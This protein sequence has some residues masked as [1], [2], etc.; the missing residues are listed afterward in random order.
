[1]SR[2]LAVSTLA[3]LVLAVGCAGTDSSDARSAPEVADTPGSGVEQAG[4]DI[5]SEIDSDAPVASSREEMYAEP[6]QAVPGGVVA[7]HFPGGIGRGEAFILHQHDGVRWE[8][9]YT[10]LSVEGKPAPTQWWPLGH[11]G[12]GWD[13]V[14]IDGPGP[15]FVLVPYTA[16]PGEYLVCATDDNALCA[17]LDVVEV[18]PVTAE[19]IDHAE[20]LREMRERYDQGDDLYF[21]ELLVLV[22][23][24][25]PE[26]AGYYLVSGRLTIALAG[27][28]DAD[29]AADA[30]AALAELTEDDALFGRSVDHVAV[31]YSWLELFGWMRLILNDAHVELP[32]HFYDIDEVENRIALGVEGSASHGDVVRDHFEQ[33]GV[34]ADVLL[35]V[36]SGPPID[37]VDE[38]GPD[39]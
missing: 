24:S 7:L 36:E 29:R 15:Q 27:E 8:P 18:A 12:A 39:D 33:F 31:D 28:A 16:P 6:D 37:D 30:A 23:E 34:P 38:G 10:L 5:D 19:A 22:A 4:G 1:M 3:V 32:I 2:G 21:D 35:I 17:S 26:F 25:V 11:P 9:A 14:G 13:D 20:L